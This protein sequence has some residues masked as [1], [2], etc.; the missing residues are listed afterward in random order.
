MSVRNV[1]AQIQ[2]FNQDRDPN[3]LKLKYQTMASSAF[4]FLRGTCHLFYQ[5][6]PAE[7]TI[8]KLPSVWVCGD[9]HLQNFGSYRGDDRLVYFDIN[10]FDESVLAPCSWD[11]ARFLTSI[12]V[13]AHT[14]GISD[15]DAQ[16]LCKCF[17]ESYTAALRLGKARDIHP[18]T[19]AGL[20][21]ELL[22]SLAKRDRK[23]F[24]T[25]RTDLKDKQRKLK[26]I[27]GK[28]F[29]VTPEQREKITNLI[30]KWAANHPNPAFFEVLD[31]AHRI[32]G[33][34]S[35]G[36][37]RYILLV[38]GN[39]SPHRNY[40]LD[41]K[42]ARSSSLYP[43]LQVH[44]PNWISEADRIVAIQ[45]RFQES[46]PALLKALELDSKSYVLREL[47]PTADRVNLAAWNGK[48]K[49]LKK[50]IQTMA[51]VTAWGQ[52]RSGGRQG[53]AI[54]DDLIAFA[55]DAEN[56]HPLLLEYAQSYAVQV[57]TDFTLFRDALQDDCL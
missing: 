5:D 52:L 37:D 40:L 35:L 22:E 7:A 57:E 24:L 14:L 19:A 41:L 34:G 26:I 55:E 13:A 12:L 2:Q 51:E 23:I 54:A 6:I 33:T 36:L 21:R 1:V 20:V 8:D 53:S 15:E 42:A 32:A 50:V 49:R 25:E 3:L 27:P 43:H 17:L 31:V 45:H 46:P 28:T 4:G 48:I 47:Q 39:G 9:L 44:Q 16:E 29:A 18:Q 11:T 56:W 38:E 30:T 10:D